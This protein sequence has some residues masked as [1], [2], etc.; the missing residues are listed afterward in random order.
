[1]AEIVPAIIAKDFDDFKDK[2]N[3]IRGNTDWVHLDVVDGKFAKNTSWGDPEVLRDY[4]TDAFISV[5]LM[6]EN[7]EEQIEAWAGSSPRRIFFHHESTDKHEEIIRICK[8]YETSVGIALKLETSEDV[9]KE[10]AD[11]I[12]A[13]LLLGVDPGF[14]GSDFSDRVYAK[15]HQ[16]RAQYPDMT[17]V[18][19][20]G[21]NPE[22][23][24]KAVD[25]GADFVV[26]GSYIYESDDP[27]EALEELKNSL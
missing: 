27:K 12:D 13:V 16:V 15:I 19:D 3:K 2:E 6:V 11:K 17:I 8:E 5:H 14:Y 25:I 26:V 24:K 20:G 4:D 23:A 18:V 22:R 7:P 1:M 9:L 10:W 21:M